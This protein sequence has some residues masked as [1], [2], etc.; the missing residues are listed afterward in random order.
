GIR[1]IYG[2][3]VSRGPEARRRPAPAPRGFTNERLFGKPTSMPRAL[4]SETP[5]TREVILDVAEREFAERGYA[6]VSMRKIAAAA[7]PHNQ[8]SPYH[9]LPHQRALY[10]AVLRPGP[11]PLFTL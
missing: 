4:A 8:A 10:E 2:A 11:T 1:L 5:S 9:H 7:G 6:G 3:R